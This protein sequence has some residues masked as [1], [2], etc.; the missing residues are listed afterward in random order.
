MRPE[1]VEWLRQSEYDLGT[2]E[3]MYNTGKYVYTAFMCQLA[4]EKAIKGLIVER[5]G[6]TPPKTHNLIQLAKI[7]KVE[8]SNSQLEFVAILN[9]AGVG[10]RYPDM[11]DNAIKRY[12]REVA[13]DYLTKT[14]EVIQW[15]VQKI[16]STQ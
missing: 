7:A 10:A 1:T 13:W 12:P 4:T 16:R 14:K 8:L 11:L 3:A 2:A 9:M 6:N 5:T 15:L